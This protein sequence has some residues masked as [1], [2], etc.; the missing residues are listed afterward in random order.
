MNKVEISYG[1][2]EAPLWLKKDPVPFVQ[3]VLEKLEKHNWDLSIL[4]CTN[5]KIRALNRQFRNRD[6]PTD[7]LAFIMGEIEGERYLP[8]DIAISP[9]M[10]EENARRFEVS[11]GEELHRLLIHGILH[12]TGMDHAS[13]DKEEPML[14]LQEKLLFELYGEELQ[15]MEMQK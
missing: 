12:L 5:E 11:P 10:A 9:E 15:G 2:I 3:S 8:G 1:E 7:V 6:E 13:E 14:I 4:F